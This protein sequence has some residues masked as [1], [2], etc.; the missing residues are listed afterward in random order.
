MKFRARVINAQQLI[1]DQVL[2]AHDLERA[3]DQLTQLGLRAISIQAESGGALNLQRWLGVGRLDF[4]VLLFSQELLALLNAGLGIVE[5]TEALSEKETDAARRQVFEKL[6]HDLR[7]GKRFSVAL[8][9]Q[10]AVFPVLYIGVVRAA[11]GTSDLPQALQRYV[12]YQKRLEAVRSKVIS[13]SIYPGI[14]I[15]VGLLV[16]LF[17]MV[18]VVPKFAEVYQGAGRELPFMSALMLSWG[19]FAAEHTSWLLLALAGVA[20]SLV[21]LWQRIRKNGGWV[22]ILAKLPQIGER[23]R[24][25]ELSRLYMTMGMLLQGGIALVKAMEVVASVV[26]MDVQNKLARARHDIES[27]VSLS[28]AFES[29]ALT[30]PI[31]QRL[32]MVGERT[33]DLGK[34]LTQSALF[35]DEEITQWIDRFMRSFEPLLM[36][37]IGLVVGV[38]VILLYMPIFDLAGSF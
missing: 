19:R 5:S 26:S 24:I 34:M 7:T 4:S 23:V 29:V 15:S 20:G 9:A 18:Y 14:L 37:A 30:T 12:D 8:Q 31:S 3:R 32:L 35:Y 36:T 6:L 13:A 38:I 25:Y 21:W 2:E 11:E 27:G 10:E 1:V 17:L 16:S 22:V 28:A 33:G